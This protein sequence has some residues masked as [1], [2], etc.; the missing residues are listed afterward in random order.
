MQ[1][2]MTAGTP[3]AFHDMD[4]VRAEKLRRLIWTIVFGAIL[5]LITLLTRII[6][7]LPDIN[8]RSFNNIRL[9]IVLFFVFIVL[10]TYLLIFT[11]NGEDRA[12]NMI[13]EHPYAAYSMAFV[14]L[15]LVGL[16]FSIFTTLMQASG[17]IFFIAF[18]GFLFNLLL[19]L[20]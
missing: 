16:T 10:A 19:L 7:R 9:F 13:N 5:I 4:M 11:T 2:N 18:W 12:N 3:R 1:D 8:L 17:V 14:F 6:D 15:I 20:A